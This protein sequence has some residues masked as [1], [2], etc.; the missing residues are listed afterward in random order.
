MFINQQYGP[1]FQYACLSRNSMAFLPVCMFI[2]KQ[3]GVPSGIHVYQ[4][5]YLPS[6]Q[7]RHLPTV[8]PSFQYTF[9]HKQTFL[10]SPHHLHWNL[11]LLLFTDLFVSE[12]MF[13]KHLGLTYFPVTK[14]FLP[15]SSFEQSNSHSLCWPLV[16]TAWVSLLAVI[17]CW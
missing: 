1:S 4:Q 16:T 15:P 12:D 17:C 7:Y 5:T 10:R 9:H 8:L 3:Y 2:N 6:F 13:L 11:C 14:C